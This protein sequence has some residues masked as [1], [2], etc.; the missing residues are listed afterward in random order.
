M[1]VFRELPVMTEAKLRE[2]E[3]WATKML[4]AFAK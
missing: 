1:I 4:R 3:E 2:A